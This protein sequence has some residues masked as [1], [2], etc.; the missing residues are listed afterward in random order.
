ML[1]SVYKLYNLSNKLKQ[2]L[3]GLYIDCDNS[4]E[5]CHKKNYYNSVNYSCL[6]AYR[7]QSI[8][9]IGWKIKRL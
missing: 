2:T 9:Y 6:L 5:N 8:L 1:V 4:Q 3:M 7:S